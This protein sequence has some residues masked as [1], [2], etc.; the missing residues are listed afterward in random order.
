MEEWMYLAGLLVLAA[1]AVGMVVPVIT[2]VWSAACATRSGG[3]RISSRNST[4]PCSG[5]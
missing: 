3:L 2:L 4:G 5:S 1:V